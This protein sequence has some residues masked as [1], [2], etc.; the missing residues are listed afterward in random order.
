MRVPEITQNELNIIVLYSRSQEVRDKHICF[1]IVP[2]IPSSFPDLRTLSVPRVLLDL[3]LSCPLAHWSQHLL[4]EFLIHLQVPWASPDWAHSEF[5]VTYSWMCLIGAWLNSCL[6]HE[7]STEIAAGHS[8]T[9]SITPF[10]FLF[11][12]RRNW[13]IWLNS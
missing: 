9:L 4:G 7:L 12:W 11:I 6:A 10:L 3:C 1:S 2:S 8:H 5:L 13:S